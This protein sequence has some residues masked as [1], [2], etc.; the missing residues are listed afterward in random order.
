[1]RIPTGSISWGHISRGQDVCTLRLTLRVVRAGKKLFLPLDL[2]V[3]I[4][5]ILLIADDLS[6][7]LRLSLPLLLAAKGSDEDPVME[8]SWRV[9][10]GSNSSQPAAIIDYGRSTWRPESTREDDLSD[11]AAPLVFLSFQ[12]LKLSGQTPE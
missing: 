3:D 5:T 1:M 10:K 4:K 8:I 2:S 7:F 12:E 9:R 11:A 6:C